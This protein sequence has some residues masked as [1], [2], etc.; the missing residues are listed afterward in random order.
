MT[1]S[2]NKI[3]DTTEIIISGRLDTTTAPQLE[4]KL[5][6]CTS[7]C[8]TLIL[9]LAEVSYISSAGLR[10]VLLAHKVMSAAGGKMRI[11]KP[12]EFCMQVFA[13]TGMDGVLTI[14]S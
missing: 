13:A 10:V 8:T 12:S 4:T 6:E 11:K 1:I 5:K 9:N 14:A 7:G 3:D 2:E